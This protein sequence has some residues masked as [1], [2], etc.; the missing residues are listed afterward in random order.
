MMR[1]KSWNFFPKMDRFFA[2]IG[3][4]LSLAEHDRCAR[5]PTKPIAK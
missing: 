2:L 5:I 3:P 4:P 1:L